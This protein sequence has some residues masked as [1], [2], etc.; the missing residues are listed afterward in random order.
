MAVIWRVVHIRGLPILLLVWLVPWRLVE[1]ESKC[2][3]ILDSVRIV[4]GLG[5]PSLPLLG[6]IGS[7]GGQVLPVLM[8]CWWRIVGISGC[9]W[10]G[11]L[12]VGVLLQRGRGM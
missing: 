6:G 3:S 2:G 9:G 4:W 12:C 7:T 5:L 10:C 8:V 1:G 11:C